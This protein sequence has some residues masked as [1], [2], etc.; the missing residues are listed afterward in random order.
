[1]SNWAKSVRERGTTATP[2]FGN[3]SEARLTPRLRARNGLI[4]PNSWARLVSNQR[5]L[6]CEAS[7]LPLSYAPWR[8]ILEPVCGLAGPASGGTAVG[9]PRTVL[10]GELA[11]PCHPQSALAGP[12]ARPR[13]AAFGVSTSRAVL[14]ARSRAMWAREPGQVRKEAAL[15]GIPHVPR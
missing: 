11:V 7:A 8:P 5:P 1:M 14:T 10:G 3:C 15:S 2:M 6:A 9:L 12:N 13:V 4:K